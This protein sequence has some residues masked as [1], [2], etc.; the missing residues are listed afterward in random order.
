MANNAKAVFQSRGSARNFLLSKT[1][2]GPSKGIER[3][4]AAGVNEILQSVFPDMLVGRGFIDHAMQQLDS[5]AQFV[6][7]AVGVD[8]TQQEDQKYSNPDV[9]DKHVEIAKILKMICR[10]K[11][12]LWGV[13]EPGLFG[14][15][16]PEINESEGLDLARDIQNRLAE[17]ADQTVTI[18]IASYPILTFGKSDMI[19]NA[20]KAFD[21]AAFF[22][23]GSAVAFDG[24]SL[25]ISG[26]KLYDNGDLKGAI[27]EFKRALELDP[28]NVN[29]HNSLGVCYGLQNE[30]ET[31]IEEF[32]KVVS[33]DPGE[34]MAMFNLGL[35]HTLR[36]QP[37]EALKFFL[38]ADKING[39]VY[40][41]AFQCGK[42][43]FESGDLEKAKPFLERASKLDPESGAVY[44]YLG[45]CY[46][47]DNLAQDAISAYK[48]A[49]KHNPRDAASM[50]ALG[51][52][53]DDQDENPEI[54]LM[55]CRES[56]GLSPENG[57]FRYR[58]GRLYFKQN[59]LDDALKEYEKA[60]QFGYD[61][62][63]DIQEIKNRLVANER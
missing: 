19:E 38:K 11:N 2:T 32:K 28:S 54:T 14:S 33:I 35:V 25:N 46:A 48:K 43:Y 3:K 9:L 7:L 20:R 12:G 41:L 34:Y 60:E 61:A 8:Q 50:S 17:K 55:F 37:E 44:R 59:R 36:G 39:D 51:C 53:F 4:K 6:A 21:H 49:I 18:G 31:A 23:P 16:F 47:T 40:E 57:L 58:L 30:Y 62:A 1:E 45:D 42:L 27:D 13:L 26:D 29:V 52:L 10:E 15:I 63:R 22:G 56:V 24:I 5:V